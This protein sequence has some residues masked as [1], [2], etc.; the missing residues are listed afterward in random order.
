MTKGQYTTKRRKFQHLTREKRAQIEILPKRGTAEQINTNLKKCR[1]Y[2]RNVRQRA[3]LALYQ[4]II[5]FLQLLYLI[6]LSFFILLFS[7]SISSVE[8]AFIQ[9]PL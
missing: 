8:A 2:F 4:S 5:M 3:D 1:R 9:K 7:M 6:F